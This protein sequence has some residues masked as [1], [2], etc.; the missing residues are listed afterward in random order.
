ML[1]PYRDSVAKKRFTPDGNVRNRNDCIIERSTFHLPKSFRIVI[2][3][4]YKPNQSEGIIPS[5]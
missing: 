3:P 2:Y 5:N 1:S 4:I